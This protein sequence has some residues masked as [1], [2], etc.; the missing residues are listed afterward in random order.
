MMFGRSPTRATALGMICMGAAGESRVGVSGA[1]TACFWTQHSELQSRMR[2]LLYRG[3]IME[4][5]SQGW[6]D[7]AAGKQR[8]EIIWTAL[9]S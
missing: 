7:A 2:R 1:A 9:N 5:R 4:Q 8:R 3:R 6:R